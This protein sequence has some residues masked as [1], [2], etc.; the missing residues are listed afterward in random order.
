MATVADQPMEERDQIVCVERL[1]MK[2]LA[3]VCVFGRG[4]CMCWRGMDT[5]SC[6]L[7]GQSC[8][9]DGVLALITNLISPINVEPSFTTPWLRHYTDGTSFELYSTKLAP[10]F[11]EVHFSDAASIVYQG[12]ALATAS[13]G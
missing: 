13:W 5:G 7:C 6:S 2:L 8:E 1:K 11:A 9:V 12:S 10:D 3:K 4:V